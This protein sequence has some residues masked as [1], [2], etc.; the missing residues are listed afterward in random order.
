M[1][2]PQYLQYRQLHSWVENDVVLVEIDGPE[3]GNVRTHIPNRQSGMQPLNEAF[4]EAHRF[5][6]QDPNI[7]RIGV[8]LR[9]EVEW[10]PAWGELIEP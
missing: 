3:T 9:D 4:E 7:K 2:I 10:L 5:A 6:C 8:W 1:Q